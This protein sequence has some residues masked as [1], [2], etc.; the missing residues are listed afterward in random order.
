MSEALKLVL[1][2][3]AKDVGEVLNNRAIFSEGLACRWHL[4]AMPQKIQTKKGGLLN[5]STEWSFL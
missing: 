1:L 2:A 4:R 3:P 5:R